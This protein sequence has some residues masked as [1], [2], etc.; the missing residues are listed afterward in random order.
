MYSVV[1]YTYPSINIGCWKQT[2]LPLCFRN[3]DF[4]IIFPHET[5]TLG[6]RGLDNTYEKDYF[7]QIV[8]C[9]GYDIYINS[10]V[11]TC[12]SRTNT[13]VYVYVINY[14]IIQT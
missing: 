13:H 7:V 5:G 4:Q 8:G 10:Y 9:I 3:I 2:S 11:Q 6:K 1:T 12:V 14:L